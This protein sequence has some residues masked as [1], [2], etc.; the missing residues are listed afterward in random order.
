MTPRSSDSETFS[1]LRPLLVRD[2][3]RLP[4]G[5]ELTLALLEYVPTGRGVIFRINYKHRELTF[6]T[7]GKKDAVALGE[8]SLEQD[9]APRVAR[10]LFSQLYEAATMKGLP[11]EG[12]VKLFGPNR[13]LEGVRER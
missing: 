1:S 5:S 4:C 12:A 3:S 7:P 2:V 13:V 9:S 6:R 10:I 11:I 8:A